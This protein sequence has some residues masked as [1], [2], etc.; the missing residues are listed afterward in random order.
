MVIQIFGKL[1]TRRKHDSQQIQPLHLAPK[2]TA[3]CIQTHASFCSTNLPHN[4]TPSKA[5]PPNTNSTT[6]PTHEVPPT[7]HTPS[8]RHLEPPKA[9]KSKT[10]Q[11]SWGWCRC[12]G[13]CTRWSV[14]RSGWTWCMPSCPRH[15]AHRRLPSISL[16]MAHVRIH[17]PAL[18]WNCSH[19]LCPSSSSRMLPRTRIRVLIPHALHP[20]SE[21]YQTPKVRSKGRTNPRAKIPMAH[22][23]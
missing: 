16:P 19:R 13:H 1:W 8:Y 17:L 3:R 10:T 2:R 15:R 4:R 9:P 20:H 6:T 5:K 14:P 22:G 18:R 7:T 11:W 21:I 23:A 12:C